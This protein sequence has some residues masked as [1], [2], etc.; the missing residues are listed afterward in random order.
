MAMTGKTMQFLGVFLFFN[1]KHPH[2]HEKCCSQ[3]VSK[4][5]EWRLNNEVE[6]PS[7]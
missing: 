5:L 6:R 3:A 1:Q 4:Q 2:Q 7:S